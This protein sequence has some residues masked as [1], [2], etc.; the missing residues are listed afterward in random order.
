MDAL[1]TAIMNKIAGMSMAEFGQPLEEKII[2]K[3]RGRTGLAVG[4]GLLTAGAVAAAIRAHK[5]KKKQVA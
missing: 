4:A 2:A 1:T 5:K 3:R